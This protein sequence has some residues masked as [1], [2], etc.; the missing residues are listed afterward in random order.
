M[1]EAGAERFLGQLRS[2]IRKSDVCSFGQNLGSELS[3]EHFRPTEY[4][5]ILLNWWVLS[6]EVVF[7]IFIINI[8]IL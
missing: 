3:K 2:S 8:Y 5:I 6:S 7:I 1:Y 4:S